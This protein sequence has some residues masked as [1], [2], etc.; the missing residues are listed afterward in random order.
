MEVISQEAYTVSSEGISLD[1][2]IWR[3]FR[4]PMDGL[5]EHMLSMQENQHLA[6]LPAILP[7]GTVVTM[8]IPQ[9]RAV[10]QTVAVVS[11]WD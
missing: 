10:A 5:L 6:D 3:R 4:K 7:P 8:P 11:L 2:M 9:R 1:L